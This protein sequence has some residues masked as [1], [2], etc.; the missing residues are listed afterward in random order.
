M[1]LSYSCRP[2]VIFVKLFHFVTQSFFL[3]MFHKFTCRLE[4]IR[5]VILNN[6]SSMVSL[7]RYDSYPY[8]KV[9]INE[10]NGTIGQVGKSDNKRKIFRS[11][12]NKMA[13]DLNISINTSSTSRS[14]STVLTIS[15][16][17]CNSGFF[18]ILINQSEDGISICNFCSMVRLFHDSSTAEGDRFERRW[19]HEAT[20][21]GPRLGHETLFPICWN[22][23]AW[24]NQQQLQRQAVLECW[25]L[26]WQCWSW[27]LLTDPN[28]SHK[29]R[30]IRSNETDSPPKL[31]H[32]LSKIS[33]NCLA[34]SV[35][36]EM[37]S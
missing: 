36:P 35:D 13:P 32:N 29:R 26:T 4:Y 3:N 33:G 14:S 12:G 18:L 19:S 11:G 22:V 8:L 23:E 31:A 20:P 15:I 2:E 17:V 27:R 7:I 30:I 25:M 5:W 37:T 1:I 24:I 34:Q 16:W 28:F 10:L 6:E 21:S 9:Q